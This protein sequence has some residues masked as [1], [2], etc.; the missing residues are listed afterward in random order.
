MGSLCALLGTGQHSHSV[1]L[2]MRNVLIV[3]GTL[4]LLALLECCTHGT[5]QTDPLKHHQKLCNNNR[6]CNNKANCYTPESMRGQECPFRDGTGNCFIGECVCRGNHDLIYPACKLEQQETTTQPSETTTKKSSN[7][8]GNR[9]TGKHEICNDHGNCE[10]RF[11]GSWPR[12]CCKQQCQQGETCIKRKCACR[13]KR[14]NNGSCSKCHPSCR[15]RTRCNEETGVCSKSWPCNQKCGNGGTCTLNSRSKEVCKT[16]GKKRRRKLNFYR[17]QCYRPRPWNQLC[18]RNCGNQDRRPK[19]QSAG[20]GRALICVSCGQGFRLVENNRGKKI[21]GPAA[22]WSPWKSWGK[23]SVSCGAGGVQS[24]TR[25]CSESNECRG[26]A[27]E[28]RDCAGN[29]ACPSLA[30]WTE[31]SK[32]SV[33]CGRGTQTR[34]EECLADA[35]KGRK[36]PQTRKCENPLCSTDCNWCEWERVGGP[37]G[38]KRTRKP[39]CPAKEGQG[40]DCVGES[41]QDLTKNG[42]KRTKD[43]HNTV[44]ESNRFYFECKGGCIN[45]QKVVHDCSGKHNRASRPEELKLVQDLCQDKESCELRPAPSFFGHRGCNGVKKTWFEWN[46]Y[47]HKEEYHRFKEG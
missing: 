26:K 40:A 3:K 14:L 46:C 19:C 43:F 10:C 35:C 13:G 4:V 8:C 5:A 42:E 20:R 22:Q 29:P 38:A 18:I 17:G 11:G 44:P 36:F 41:E 45:I 23:C 33:S 24:R 30:P 34:T 25:E 12:D 7:L 9:C 27:S 31:W 37:C 1:G 32:C 2:K 47:N 6:D 39:N 15:R 16:C 28:T 21:C